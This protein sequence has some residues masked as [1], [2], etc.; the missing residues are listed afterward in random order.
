[1]TAVL[2]CISNSFQK[3]QEIAKIKETY[4]EKG[5]VELEGPS[6]LGCEGV[7]YKC[8]L[9]DET[10]VLPKAEMKEKIRQFLHAQLESEDKGLAA[11][12]MIHTLN[13]DADKV[14]HC[15]FIRGTKPF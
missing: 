6:M 14:K 9:I 1:M 2:Y 8:P 7:F 3:D 15:Y 5:T 13:K 10:L 4:G 12:L 11:C